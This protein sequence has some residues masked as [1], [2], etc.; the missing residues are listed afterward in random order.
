MLFFSF[1]MA[2]SQFVLPL[3]IVHTISSG[4][5]IFVSFWDYYLNGVSINK[6]QMKGIIASLVGMTLVVNGR[7]I[8][9][10][11]DPTYKM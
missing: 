10:F 4:G 3:P 5:I 9:S 8:L 2:F 1:V 7:M 6:E 11:I